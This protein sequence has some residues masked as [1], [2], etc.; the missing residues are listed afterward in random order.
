METIRW[1]AN[2][3][4]LPWGD[5]LAVSLYFRQTSADGWMP[6]VLGLPDVGEREWDTESVPDG[7]TYQIRAVARDTSLA[8]AEDISGVFAVENNNQAP[9]SF[10]L[11]SPELG[12]TVAVFKPMLIWQTA[13]D[14][15]AG[16]RVSYEVRYWLHGESESPIDAGTD[17]V[18]TDQGWP[19]PLQD[20]SRYW[21]YVEATDSL[22]PETTRSSNTWWFVTNV[23]IRCQGRQNITV[24]CLTFWFFSFSIR[25]KDL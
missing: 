21:W 2:D 11:V 9:N 20:D 14:I 23:A 24:N 18:L 1:T 25:L 7:L 8:E 6:I 10:D 19:D 22:G 15:D 5:T 12:S 16:D 4:D 3:P 13:R 17:T